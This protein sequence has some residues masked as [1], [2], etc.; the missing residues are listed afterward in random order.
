MRVATLRA[1]T[2]LIAIALPNATPEA[3]GQ[4]QPARQS[5]QT[6]RLEVV[7]DAWISEVGPEANGNNGGAT[8]L[9]LKSIQEM[10]LL[11]IDTK[12]LLGRTIRSALL[13]VKKAGDEPLKRVTISS[14]GA[15]WYE[16]TGS[17]YEV[18]PG[19]VTF[20]H[21]RHP[22]LPWSI[23]GGDICHVVL[24]NGGTTWRMADASPPDRDDWQHVPVDP[25]VAAARLAGISHGFLAFDDTGS[26]WTRE[27]ES[28]KF[29]LFPNR[30][31]YSREQN[32]ASAPYFT[33]ELGPGDSRPPEAAAGLRLEP[34]SALL[35][36][37]EALVSW[38][39]PRDAGP[40]GTLGFF[41]SLDG[42]PLPRELIPMAG[43]PG[44]RVQ[45]HLHD[46][47]KSPRSRAKLSVRAVDAAGNRGPE[48]TTSIQFS[49]REPARL[50]QVKKAAARPLPATALPTVV[51][52]E[53]VI[54]D[55][56]DKVNPVTGELIPGQPDEYLTANHL[57][58]SADRKI[59]LFAAAQRVRR[60][61]NP[62][63]RSDSQRCNQA[64]A[65]L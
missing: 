37:G 52:A 14:V 39:T 27:G 43:A 29:R 26:E 64:R 25:K 16:G 38:I 34:E 65:D 32:R 57:W 45:M 58:N 42:S 2:V 51:G 8:R 49:T 62:A 3:A 28:F 10:S 53:V 4:N 48:T 6:V 22:D 56:L 41:V 19:G 30:F 7:R 59:A 50:P 15:E 61:S 46:L 31:V 21:R 54:L 44:A 12:T 23:G 47:K 24:G 9:K 35:P 13:H 17:G 1:I 60:V 33:F 40:A 55:E 5:T 63:A 18:Q 20:R 36:S 11:D